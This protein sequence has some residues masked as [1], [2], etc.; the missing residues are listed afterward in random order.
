MHSVWDVPTS[1]ASIGGGSAGEC[2]HA[3]RG[4]QNEPAGRILFKCLRLKDGNK[5]QKQNRNHETTK[6]CD[7]ASRGNGLPSAGQSLETPRKRE[8]QRRIRE[9]TAGH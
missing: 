4:S 8:A 1:T 9:V 2:S 5:K 6:D 7:K 3:Q